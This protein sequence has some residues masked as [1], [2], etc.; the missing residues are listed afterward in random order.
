MSFIILTD[1]ACNLGRDLR[2]KFNIEYIPFTVTCEKENNKEYLA[3]LDWETMSAKEYYDRM[4][5]GDVFRTSLISIGTYE[6]YF[7]KFL[8]EGKDV[9]YVGVS[10]GLSGSFNASRLAIE[11]LSQKYPDRKIVAVDSLRALGAQSLIVIK[12]SEM[13]SEEKTME[14]I[15]EWIKK[16]RNKFHQ[17]G[18]VEDMVYLKRAGRISGFKH[19]MSK[20]LKIKPIIISNDKGENVS[21]LTVKGRLNSMKKMIELTKENVINPNE[22]TL[23]LI[24]AD[25]EEAIN[26]L[27]KLMFEAVP[28]KEVYTSNT[29]PI[30]GATTGPG[31]LGVFF[32]GTEV[33]N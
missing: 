15:A 29:S 14:E 28:F 26:E 2:E 32:F 22:Q 17:Y 12:A 9:L 21:I 4:R 8:K 5:N 19:I 18:T 24:H 25:D 31:M 1:G 10:S 6:E 30:V 20:M 7:E 16:N 23:F 3:T 33:S 27:K 13:R 11:S